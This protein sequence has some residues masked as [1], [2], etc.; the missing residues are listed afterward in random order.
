M[1]NPEKHQKVRPK[2]RLVPLWEEAKT[3]NKFEVESPKCLTKGTVNSLI[4]ALTDVT[5]VEAEFNT[6]LFM[7]YRS[8]IH[9]V[10]LLDKLFERFNVPEEYKR[11]SSRIQFRSLVAIR[12][13][14]KLCVNI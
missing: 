10:T 14:L 2:T 12:E 3:R 5:V 11:Q 7:T 13:M 6:V 1:E 9:P 8:Y 4:E